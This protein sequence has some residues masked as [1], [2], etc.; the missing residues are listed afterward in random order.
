MDPQLVKNIAKLAVSFGT[1]IIV[2]GII[3]NNVSTRTIKAKLVVGAA[4][5]V[6]AG[7][8]SEKT[9]EY[10]DRSIDEGIEFFNKH[11]LPRFQK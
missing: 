10:V 4:A 9:D 1:T 6:L 3:S 2:N 8:I 11:V 5:I 7:M